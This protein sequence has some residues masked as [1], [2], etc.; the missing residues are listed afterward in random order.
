MESTWAFA[1]ANGCSGSSSS[2]SVSRGRCVGELA[3]LGERLLLL[4]R[5]ADA[6]AGREAEDGDGEGDTTP[7]PHAVRRE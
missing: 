3:H 7:C 6:A 2:A 4:G 5:E 1:N